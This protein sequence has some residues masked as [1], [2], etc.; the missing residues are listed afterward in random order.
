MKFKDYHLQFITHYTQDYSYIDSARI[1]LE[2]GC[3]WVQLRMKNAPESE[4]E[5]AAL[6]IQEMC[7]SCGATFIVDDNVELASFSKNNETKELTFLIWLDALAGDDLE[8][9]KISFD[10]VFE[11]I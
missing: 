11:L 3:K 2:G 9:A 6:V 10:V 8:G 1:A 5:Q 4:M 7:K